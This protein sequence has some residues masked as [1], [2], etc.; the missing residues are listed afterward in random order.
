MDYNAD[1]IADYF[2]ASVLP[3]LLPVIAKKNKRCGN[4]SSVLSNAVPVS[5]KRFPYSAHIN[6]KNGNQS[7]ES[8]SLKS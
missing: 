4:K 5:G 2:T 7:I 1:C 3:E 6:L 8:S